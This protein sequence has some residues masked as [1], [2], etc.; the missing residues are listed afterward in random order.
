METHKNPISHM[1][2]KALRERERER[3]IYSASPRALCI[4]DSTKLPADA[5]SFGIG[6]AINT[7]VPR[8]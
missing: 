2:A 8:L 4:A 7:P 5:Y 6:T 3:E 1:R